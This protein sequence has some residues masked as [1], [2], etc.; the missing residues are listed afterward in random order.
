MEALLFVL[1]RGAA[2]EDRLAFLDRRHPPS[3][4]AATIAHT[5]DLVDHR[6]RGIARAQEI[7]MQRMHMAIRLDCLAGRRHTLAE[8]L[9]AEQL[10]ET[11]VLTD[12]TK[13][14]LLDGFQAQQGDQFVQY[15]THAASPINA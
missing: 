9:A 5:V 7:A 2:G 1:E 14:V 12:A 15:L 3:A 10:A 13:E 4:E 11:Q 8:H 6:Q